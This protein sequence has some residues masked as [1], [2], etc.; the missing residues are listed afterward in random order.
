MLNGRAAYHGATCRST[1]ELRAHGTP[2]GIRT[3]DQPLMKRSNRHL[4]HGAAR[5]KLPGNRP[6]LLLRPVA[7][8]TPSGREVT[9]SLHHRQFLQNELGNARCRIKLT[10][11]EFSF[12]GEPNP[13]RARLA[14]RAP[15]H[16][17]PAGGIRT[18]TTV[19]RSTGHLHHQLWMTL[20]PY[21]QMGQGSEGGRQKQNRASET[22]RA[23]MNK[24]MWVAALFKNGA[25]PQRTSVRSAIGC[26][27]SPCS[28]RR[29]P[30]F[31]RARS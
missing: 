19:S 2:G 5:K 8:P 1:A 27:L 16:A 23:S 20:C 30:R 3:R 7:R 24:K 26:W 28:L 4:H 31:E 9:G 25:P 14:G 17:S 22:W 29:A 12:S 15:R 18:R 13:R 6:G 10:T 21:R 11:R